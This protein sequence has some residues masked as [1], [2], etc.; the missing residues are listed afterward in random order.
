MP[1]FI[2]LS[3]QEQQEFLKPRQGVTVNL[4]PYE[5]FLWEIKEGEYGEVFLEEGDV[6]RTVKRRI[7]LVANSQNKAIRWIKPDSSRIIFK[8]I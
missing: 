4:A 6:K 2:R 3:E 5:E 8:V 7:S 1:N